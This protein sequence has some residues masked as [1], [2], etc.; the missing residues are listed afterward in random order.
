MPKPKPPP[1]ANSNGSTIAASSF[2]G[3]FTPGSK[4]A[5]FSLA[6]PD[7]PASNRAGQAPDPAPEMADARRRA[8]CSRLRNVSLDA[9]VLS[10]ICLAGAGSAVILSTFNLRS[11]MD[12]IDYVLASFERTRHGTRSQLSRV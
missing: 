3:L 4:S 12:R 6:Q 8:D 7:K 5:T 11:N 1:I 9:C 2:S 10:P